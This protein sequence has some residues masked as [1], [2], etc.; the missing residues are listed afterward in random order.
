MF[1]SRRLKEILLLLI[2]KLLLLLLSPFE[3]IFKVLIVLLISFVVRIQF[4]YISIVVIIL[5]L[6]V[7]KWRRRIQFCTRFHPTT[8]Q[9]KYP[10][11]WRALHYTH[12]S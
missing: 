7:Q 11:P 4:N 5:N 6:L 1:Y 10:Q 8:A 2:V 9:T 12:E 3:I